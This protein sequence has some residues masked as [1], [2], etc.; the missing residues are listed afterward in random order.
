MP[1]IIYPDYS[2]YYEKTSRTF[3]ST[4]DAESSDIVYDKDTYLISSVADLGGGDYQFNR[5]YLVFDVSVSKQPFTALYLNIYP[6]SSTTSK[7]IIITYGGYDGLSQDNTDYP[8]YIINNEIDWAGKAD[9]LT[10]KYNE[11]Y[12]RPNI[13][14]YDNRGFLVIGIIDNN[15]FNNFYGSNSLL[16][17][18][19]GSGTNPPYLRYTTQ[20]GYQNSI[21][22][23]SS[24]SVSNLNGLPLSSISK[25]N[26]I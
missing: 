18:D 19:S 26:V 15:D 1:P 17:I 23:L 12:L 24:S 3:S 14:A 21:L 6:D 4:R 8:N 25:V 2:A 22:G 9:I 11:F 5:T 7:S 16:N 10:E 13:A 20:A